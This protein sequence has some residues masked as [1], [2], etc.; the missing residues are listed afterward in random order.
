VRSPPRSPLPNLPDFRAHSLH[1]DP[2]VTRHRIQLNSLVA[3]LQ[4]S[5]Q[6][7]QQGNLVASHRASLRRIRPILRDNRLQGQHTVLLVSLRPS[8][9]VGRQLNRRLG[10][11]QG[12]A[13]SLLLTLL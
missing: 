10:L 12:Q 1:L 8:R 2:Q 6:G 7:N 5:Q 9:R 11:P 13:L 3:N 4:A